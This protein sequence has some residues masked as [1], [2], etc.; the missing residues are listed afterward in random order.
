[1]FVPGVT[2][3]V[4]LFSADGWRQMFYKSDGTRIR[5]GVTFGS[6]GG[7]T[8]YKPDLAA[9]DGV[10][11]TSPEFFLNPFFG[12][13]AA[14]PHAAAVAALLK[15]AVPTATAT[16][17]RNAILFG[18]VDIAAQGQDQQ[19]GRGM[20]SAM[21]ALSQI[22]A[23]PAVS[24]AL[25]SA[26][27][28][29]SSGGFVVPGGTGSISVQLLNEGGA[30]ANNVKGTLT[31]STA[32]VT[33]VNGTSTFPSLAPGA[34][35]TNATPFTFSVSSAV[36]CGQVL[37]FNLS[38]TFTGKGTSPTVFAFK[39]Q[40][41]VPSSTAVVGNFATLT[42]IPDDD[43]AGVNIPIPVSGAGGI[44]GVTFSINGSAC[45]A[46]VGST[47]VGIDHSWVGDIIATLTSPSGTTVTLMNRPGGTGNSGNNFC[48]T[49]LTDSASTSIQDIAVA[50]APW[51]GSFKPAQP[52][53]AFNGESGDGTWVLNVSDNAFIDTGNVRDVSVAVTGF[54]CP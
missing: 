19:S 51:T 8:R 48:Q 20:V 29:G 9:P 30:Q 3:P 39:V 17:L 40:T 32:G 11:T 25:V 37:F 53:S 42:P 27:T 43:P 45:N 7:E 49:V 5:G 36:P 6:G 24:L 33:V 38:V 35:G 23:R 41:G 4:E 34:S 54:S 47:T 2:T 28:T 10:S 46:N 52:L 14:A 1:V 50:G 26:T 31:S 16:R 12:T 13:S 15:S 18:A 22:G 21:E 44:S